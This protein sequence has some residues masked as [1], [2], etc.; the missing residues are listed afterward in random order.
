MFPKVTEEIKLSLEK[1]G[2]KLHKEINSTSQPHFVIHASLCS[3]N[4]S[5]ARNVKKMTNYYNKYGPDK[6]KVWSISGTT[7]D[8]IYQMLLSKC[9][10]NV[11]KI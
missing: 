5:S 9:N 10:V 8:W 11:Y 7:A 4:S 2:L 1:K 3:L 6:K